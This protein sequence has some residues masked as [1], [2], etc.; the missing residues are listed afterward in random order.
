MK[1]RRDPLEPGPERQPF[2][3]RGLFRAITALLGLFLLGLGILVLTSPA[4]SGLLS[5]AA[6][7]V[8]VLLGGNAVVAAGRGTRAW[9]V[10]IG[11]LP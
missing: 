3:S 9:L 8:L 6:G 4:T 11:P 5:K 1:T 7:L 2:Y 10:R